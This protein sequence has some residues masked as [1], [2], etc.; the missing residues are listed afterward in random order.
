M[1]SF[2]GLRFRLF[3]IA[4]LSTAAIFASSI[5]QADAAAYP[6]GGSTFTGSA[7]GW[8][9]S[10]N[11]NVPATLVCEASAGY[12]GTAGDPAGSL[13]LKSQVAVNALALFKVTASEESPGFTAAEGGAA[14]LR[15][16]R[17]F[18][19]G[20]LLPLT[21]HATYTVTLLDHTAG[22]RQQAIEETLEAA[23]PFTPKAA[24]VNLTAGH[25]YSVLIAA[26][27]GSTVATVGLTGASELRFDNV[28]VTGSGGGEGGS[29]S[30]PGPGLSG[31]GGGGGANG[32]NGGAGGTSG[33]VSADRLES[34]I[35]SAG[36][37]GPATLKGNKLAVKAKCP[38]KIGRPCTITLRGM[39][40]RHEPATA[41]RK[42]KVKKAKVK[43]LV[44][45]V[46]PAARAKLKTKKKI[47]F[48]E[49][50]KAGK[51][52]ATVFKTL[53]LIHKK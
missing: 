24:S 42:A 28:S 30:G 13:G 51:A 21:P 2:N 41:T 1:S 43:S 31:T 4:C 10:A 7:E 53:K 48:K 36:L 33:G 25:S 29:G 40:N 39:L 26:E 18:E 52:K 23:S 16:E 35:Q 12:D 6:A 22:T 8:S 19:P 45:K 44:L 27:V 20:G 38:A 47:L 9:S 50:V 3:A 17:Q 32:A 46:K 34:L 5:G 15:L 49:T 37:V 11:C 14:T